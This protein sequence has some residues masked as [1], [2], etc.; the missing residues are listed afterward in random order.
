MDVFEPQKCHTKLGI[1]YRKFITCV[2]LKGP[3]D[4]VN[5]GRDSLW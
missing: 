3:L 5:F 2:I 4:V 1:L